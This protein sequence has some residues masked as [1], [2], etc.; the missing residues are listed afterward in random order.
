[1]SDDMLNSITAGFESMSVD[2]I[3]LDNIG[4]HYF[5]DTTTPA[6][7]INGLGTNIMKKSNSTN[8]P[9]NTNG[10][11]AWLKLDAPSTAV[12]NMVKEVYRLNTQGGSQPSNCSGMPPTFEVQ[13]AADYFFY[14]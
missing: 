14:V 5:V 8:A 9:N 1:M 12:S 2:Q 6:F 11:V 4:I 3:P 7:V 10:D 13:Y